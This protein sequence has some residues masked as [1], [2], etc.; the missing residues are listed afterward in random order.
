MDFKEFIAE[1]PKTELHIHLEAVAELDSLVAL[2]EKYNMIADLSSREDFRKYIFVNNLQEMVEK[3]F[4]FQ[5][6]Y[7][8][9]DDYRFL[10][11]DVLSYAQK[12][13]IHY[14][15]AFVSPS[16]VKRIGKVSVHDF[17][18]IISQ[19][20]SNI[21]QEH[22]IDIKLI[23]DLSR[24]FGP[25]NAQDNLD[26]VK[27]YLANNPGSPIIGFGLGGNEINN[28][29]R[30][31]KDVFRQAA[32]LGLHVVAHAGEE[33]GVSSIREAIDDLHAERIGHG[34]SAIYDEKMIETLRDRKIP[35]EICVTS[36]MATKKFV[37]SYKSHPIGRFIEQGLIVT[38]NT[39][40]PVLF[41]VD[42]NSEIMKLHEK[43]G[44]SEEII[45]QLLKNNVDYSFMEPDR[46]KDFWE[47]RVLPVI[48][49]YSS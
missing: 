30:I 19:E 25:E 46:K 36:N 21:K 31:Y 9:A 41:D 13:N 34:T 23:I 43:C 10:M 45:Q 38:V 18:S 47:K 24:S 39:D 8:E 14:M 15:E 32:E 33:V 26:T 28:P 6:L 7:R 16:M 35:L 49:R 27:K 37:D 2:N 3:F 5:E 42:L 17:Y 22:E 12:N 11:R 29:A 44:L 20:I 40:D 1:V 48:K 4:R